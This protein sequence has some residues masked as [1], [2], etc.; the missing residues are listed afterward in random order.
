MM[1]TARAASA[2]PSMRRSYGAREADPAVSE[3][4]SAEAGSSRRS[5]LA[6]RRV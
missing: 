5:H 6:Q 3:A 4:S 1:A 2:E